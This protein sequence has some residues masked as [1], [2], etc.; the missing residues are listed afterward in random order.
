MDSGVRRTVADILPVSVAV[1]CFSPCALLLRV[2]EN[3]FKLLFGPPFNITGKRAHLLQ[4]LSTDIKTASG[5]GFYR[6]YRKKHHP[7]AAMPPP[8]SVKPFVIGR[9]D[10]LIANT[11]RGAKASAVMYS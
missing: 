11:A 5:G 10:F 7:G 9:K 2:C 8:V 6:K 3:P 1:A 4:S